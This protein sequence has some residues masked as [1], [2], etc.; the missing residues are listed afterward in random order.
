VERERQ[1][2]RNSWGS[3]ICTAVVLLVLFFLP[4]VE[5]SCRASKDSQILLAKRSGWQIAVGSATL[6]DAESKQPSTDFEK[7][8]IAR[9][10]PRPRPWVFLGLLVPVTL[11]ILGVAAQRKRIRASRFGKLVALAGAVGVGLSLA[12]FLMDQSKNVGRYLREERRAE[13]V[14]DGK[15]KAEI[16]Q[17]LAKMTAVRQIGILE[18]DGEGVKVVP[19]NALWITLG[20]YVFLLFV[21]SANIP[22]SPRLTSDEDGTDELAGRG[23]SEADG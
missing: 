4:W 13:L 6:Y 23:T 8:R 17:A 20:L 21:G 15:G 11:L 16:E 22:P 18:Q 12:V 2:R 3:A 19:A 10:S 14:K 7:I 1:I 9:T 5:L